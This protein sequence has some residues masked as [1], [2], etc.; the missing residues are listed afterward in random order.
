MNKKGAE[1]TAFTMIIYIIL[2]AIFLF[3]SGF[4]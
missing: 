3:F 2:G 1:D 4:F